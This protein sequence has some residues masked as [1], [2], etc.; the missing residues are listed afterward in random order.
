MISE[1]LGERIG[2][3]GGLLFAFS[4]FFF[5]GAILGESSSEDSGKVLHDSLADFSAIGT[6]VMVSTLGVFGV[7]LFGA[8]LRAVLARTELAPGR[9]SNLVLPAIAGGAA[10][11]A[12]GPTIV[13]AVALRIDKASSGND[14][15]ALAHAV[16]VTG[17]FYSGIFFGVAALA[18]GAVTLRGGLLPNWFG[19]FS[20]LCAALMVFGSAT[21][22]ISVPLGFLSG[23]PEML[24]F[25][26]AAIVLFIRSGAS[27][28]VATAD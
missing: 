28:E 13:Q 11:G 4:L 8:T 5:N 20:I 19:W 18:V 6:S 1:R 25:V 17:F 2:A 22:A 3:L 26:V 7:L 10:V 24:Y 23:I 16:T 15:A 9:L 27:V 12:V 14:I 21:S